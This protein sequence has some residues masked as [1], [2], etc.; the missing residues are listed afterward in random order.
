MRSRCCHPVRHLFMVVAHRHART[1]SY[2]AERLNPCLS[3][4]ELF[5]TSMFLV[6]CAW[7]SRVTYFGV[8]TT[9]NAVDGKKESCCNKAV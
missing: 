5:H 1:S 9:P 2:S 8:G 6:T 3:G 4:K 7:R